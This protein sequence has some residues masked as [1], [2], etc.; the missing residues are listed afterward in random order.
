MSIIL[1]YFIAACKY[2]EVQKKAQAEIDRVVGTDRLP[3]IADRANLPYV[4]AL[5]TELYRWLPV[6]PLALPHRA[7][8]DDVYNG[9]LIP[10]DAT[11]FANVWNFFH[12][13]AV[14]KEPFEFN[15]ERF[16]GETPERDPRDIGVFGFGRRS[17]PGE[18]LADVSVWISVTKAIAAFN[19][20]KAL[21]EQGNPIEP[22]AEGMD[23]IIS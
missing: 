3:T 21:D 14:Y 11:I 23:G 5:V 10:K 8:N 9:M 7:V 17:C 16:L 15:P 6:A 22:V 13:P 12:N 18:H 1:N 19:V 2:P 4:E 20:E